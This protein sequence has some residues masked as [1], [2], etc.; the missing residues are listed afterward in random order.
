LIRNDIQ[1][2]ERAPKAI[3]EYLT[4]KGGL[5]VY[6]EPVFRLVWSP[7]RVRIRGGKFSDW[8][9]NIAG[10]ER[11]GFVRLKSGLVVPNHRPI[12][13]VIEYREVRKY[14][15]DPGWV[16]ERWIPATYYGARGDWEMRCV[17]G[18]S[19]CFGGPFPSTGEYEMCH[20]SASSEIPSISQLSEIIDRC[21]KSKHEHS[22]NVEQIV[23]DRV[24][25]EEK[26]YH[27]LLKKEREE[28]EAFV[29]DLMRPFYSDSLA[30]GAYRG[31]I[32]RG[33][34]ITEHVGN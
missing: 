16:M 11:G 34:G 18:T 8:D 15:F 24:D 14:D 12:R 23:A 28:Y 27:A 20:N 19:I 1:G 31:K 9:D 5:N 10:H 21:E 26:A 4:R 33:L 3:Q 13:T 25:E 30:M 7:T 32:A 29:S 2:V 17:P 22:G 6:G